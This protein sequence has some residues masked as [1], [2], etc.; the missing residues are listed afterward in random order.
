MSLF[1]KI[2]SALD[3]LMPSPSETTPE[4][5]CGHV[6]LL[7]QSSRRIRDTLKAIKQ[8]RLVATSSTTAD[9]QA[10]D[11]LRYREMINQH[12]TTEEP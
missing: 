4:E 12:D 3:R 1:D 8:G 2:T 7:E 6:A 11:E 5:E 10:T 9:L